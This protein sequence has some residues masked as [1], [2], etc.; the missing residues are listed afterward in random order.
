MQQI[1]QILA[2]AATLSTAS[3]GAI[4]GFNYGST[5]VSNNA[6]QQSDFETLFKTAKNL[7]GTENAFTSARLYTMIVRNLYALLHPHLILTR[8]KSTA[9]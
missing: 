2:L 8:M 9:S 4:Q 7:V 5:G 6:L 1:S 3:A